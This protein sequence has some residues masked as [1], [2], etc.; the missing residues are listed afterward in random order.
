M[1]ISDYIVVQPLVV[2]FVL[3]FDAIDLHP[4]I[5]SF[6]YYKS[7]A[8]W[9]YFIIRVVLSSIAALLVYGIESNLLPPVTALIGVLASIT[10]LQSLS[11]SVG[12]ND[13]A[14]VGNLLDGYKKKMVTDESNRRATKDDSKVL[15]LVNELTSI[16]P[17]R[18][19]D[20]HLRLMLLQAKWSSEDIN[21]HIENI[22]QSVKESQNVDPEQY[23]AMIFATQIADMNP[24]YAR[25]LIETGKVLHPKSKQVIE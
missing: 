7:F 2:L 19:L 20:N 9:A 12:G 15:Q 21:K 18:Q 13:I 24:D 17:P 4:Q 25:N 22:V 14:K 16:Y 8:Y 10:I 1:P 5:G 23:I 11:L 3:I 6:G